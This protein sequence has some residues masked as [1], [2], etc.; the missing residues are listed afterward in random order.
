MNIANKCI[1][2]LDDSRKFGQLQTKYTRIG[3]KIIESRPE[4]I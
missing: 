3:H 4:L 2:I 1:W